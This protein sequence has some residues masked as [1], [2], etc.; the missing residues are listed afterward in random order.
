MLTTKQIKSLKAMAHHLKPVVQVG[1]GGITG[2]L[3]EQVDLALTAHE[4]IKVSV[5]KSSPLTRDEV[6]RTLTEET[7][8]TCVQTIGHLTVLF[9]PSEDNP[10]IQI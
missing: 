2:N 8:A 6:A 9:R 10:Q 4:L 3:I 1:K 7:G 5:Q